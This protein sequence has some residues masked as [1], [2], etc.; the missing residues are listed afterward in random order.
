MSLLIPSLHGLPDGKYIV[1]DY[2]YINTTRLLAPY[3]GHQR[4]DD[5]K[6]TFN[7]YLS[8]CRKWI[9]QA[10]GQLTNVDNRNLAQNNSKN[11][12]DQTI[13]EGKFCI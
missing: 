6:D 1:A 8:Q 4:S 10:F 5:S 9:E 2:A 3:S 12:A 7:I 11:R 13:G